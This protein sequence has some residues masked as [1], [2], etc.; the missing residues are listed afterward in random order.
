M[1]IIFVNYIK[2]CTA[3]LYLGVAFCYLDTFV[4]FPNDATFMA[5][6][7]SV[8]SLH[9]SHTLDIGKPK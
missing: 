9:F 1:I 7:A 3:K 2:K 5:S 6:A 4:V 8:P